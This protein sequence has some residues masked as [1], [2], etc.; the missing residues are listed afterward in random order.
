MPSFLALERMTQ[1]EC[2]LQASP[3]YIGIPCLNKQTNPTDIIRFVFYLVS[4][5]IINV[6]H[7]MS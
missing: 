2:E 3:E 5:I 6:N 4:M 1:K 7:G